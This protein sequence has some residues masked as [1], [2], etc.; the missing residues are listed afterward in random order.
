MVMFQDLQTST[1]S[2]SKLKNI[3]LS[4]SD[5]FGVKFNYQYFVKLTV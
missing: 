1:N 4:I 2:V 5:T 3:F